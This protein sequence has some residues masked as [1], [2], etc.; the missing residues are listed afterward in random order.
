MPTQ[1][2]KRHAGE[3]LLSEVDQRFRNNIIIEPG[4]KLAAGTVLGKITKAPPAASVTGAIAEDVLTV[5]AVASGKLAV[6]QVISGD[7]VTAGTT[8]TALG[9]GTGGAGTYIVS[10]EQTVS[11]TT[12]TANSAKAAAVVGDGTGAI[13]TITVSGDAKPGDYLLTVTKAASSAG[14]FQ[15]VDPDG[16]VVGVGTVGVAFSGGGLSFTLA[17]GSPD[18]SL[19]DSITITVA[20]GNGNYVLHN[21]DATD[22]S[23]HA[24]AILYDAVDASTGA[25]A[26]VAIERM[27]V[28]GASALTWAEGISAGAKA[29]AVARLA[30]Q[31]LLIQ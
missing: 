10:E 9:T 12:I 13:G 30:E 21:P 28:V 19:G 3:F 25:K 26:G 29:A 1:T 24:A 14:D 27:A 18:F 4:Q 8:I 15:L 22:G 23:Q 2:E 6:G 7:G 5:S 16:I 11:S 17:D 20:A 31:H